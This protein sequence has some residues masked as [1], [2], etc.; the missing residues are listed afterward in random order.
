VLGVNARWAGAHPDALAA[1]LVALHKASLWCA[2]PG[3]RA[4]LARLLAQPAYVG[5]D[6]D[7]LL[8][9]LAG[10]LPVG[11][12]VMKGVAD[13]FVP[14]AKAA[15]FPWKSHALWFYSQMVRWGQIRDSEDHRRIATETYRPDIYRSA[16]K[17][18]GIAMPSASS[19]VEGALTTETPV[20]SSGALT[21]GPDGFFDGGRFDPDDLDGYIAAQRLR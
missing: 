12:G 11:G 7:L 6:A 16:L 2:K 15:T 5:R 1:L 8:P 3:N 20:G 10:N 18:L 21:L 13:F 9:A 17:A 19:K 4:E 14:S